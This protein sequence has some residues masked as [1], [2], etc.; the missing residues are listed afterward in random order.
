M[1][2]N[3]YLLSVIALEVLMSARDCSSS[4][5]HHNLLIKVACTSAGSSVCHV[6]PG[7]FIRLYAIRDGGRK[8]ELLH[9][10]KVDGIPGALAPF[11]GRLLAG[12]ET[13]VRLYEL[14]KKKLLRKCEHRKCAK[15]SPLCP[16]SMSHN[17][18]NPR[19]CLPRLPQLF[20]RPA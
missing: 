14:G 1:C 17:T 20:Q 6:C 12:I 16:F 18:R 4:A 8:L 19:V 10:T 15:L 3:P 7:G 2:S 9:K 13:T 5:L 11:K